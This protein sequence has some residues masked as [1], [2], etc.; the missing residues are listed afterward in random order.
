MSIRAQHAVFILKTNVAKPVNLTT[1]KNGACVEHAGQQIYF[2]RYYS[3]TL[4]LS[5][6][7]R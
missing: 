6:I 2:G 1:K 7:Y 5:F 3:F 4:N